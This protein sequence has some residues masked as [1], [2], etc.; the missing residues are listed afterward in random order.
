MP[1]IALAPASESIEWVSRACREA[2]EEA[3]QDLQLD[4]EPGLLLPQGDAF[5]CAVRDL[6]LFACASAPGGCPLTLAAVRPAA[7]L[8][9]V[10]EA[11]LVL[12]WQVAG[13]DDV[14]GGSVSNVVPIRAGGRR[15]AAL[16]AGVEADQL[17]A[18]F[19]GL[20]LSLD[21][22]VLGEGEEIA[23]RVGID[24]ATG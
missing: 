16:V 1:D 15:G 24:A 20:G 22:E 2:L 17:R 9:V 7:R 12:R 21:L 14:G 13:L 10:G 3:A 5:R 19:G 11:N 23:A 18:L 4:V 8:T 6:V